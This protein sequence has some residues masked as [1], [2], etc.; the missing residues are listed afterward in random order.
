LVRNPGAF[1]SKFKQDEDSKAVE[2]PEAAVEAVET[3]EPVED[4]YGALLAHKVGCKC[5]KSACMKKVI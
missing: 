2:V 1:D 5:R 3:A 4:K